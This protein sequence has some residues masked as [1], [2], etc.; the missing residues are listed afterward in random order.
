MMDSSDSGFTTDQMTE[1]SMSSM[2]SDRLD[3]DYFEQYCSY[4]FDDLDM[5]IFPKI[6]ETEIDQGAD[7]IA[8]TN[9]F[10]ANGGED[11][12]QWATQRENRPEIN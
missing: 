3:V 4:I 10:F 5:T 7:D 6:E 9:I 8:A 1:S 12:W 2:R 11:P